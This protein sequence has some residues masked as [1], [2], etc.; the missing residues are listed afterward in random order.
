[1]VALGIFPGD[2][3]ELGNP[4]PGR[5]IGETVGI[6]RVNDGGRPGLGEEPSQRLTGNPVVVRESPHRVDMS[7]DDGG[8]LSRILSRLIFEEHPLLF[9][10]L[11]GNS[12]GKPECF[13]VAWG[14]LEGS[15]DGLVCF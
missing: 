6:K 2:A 10:V 12:V 4:I 1:M 8:S 11:T 9:A 3:G 7:V 15:E 13:A 14:H 5:M